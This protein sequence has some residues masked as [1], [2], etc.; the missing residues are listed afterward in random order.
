MCE[1]ELQPTNCTSMAGVRSH[2][3]ILVSGVNLLAGSPIQT[4]TNLVIIVIVVVVVVAAVA[5]EAFAVKEEF[6][7]GLELQELAVMFSSKSKLGPDF[8]FVKCLDSQPY[9]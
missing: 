6:T 9:S 5:I 8:G 4:F 7:G 2:H 3:L 1:M